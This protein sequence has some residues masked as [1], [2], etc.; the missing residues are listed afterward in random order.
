MS[1]RHR[2]RLFV[3]GAATIL[4]AFAEVLTLGAVV[5]LLVVISNPSRLLQNEWASWVFDVFGVTSAPQMVLFTTIVFAGLALTAGAFRIWLLWLSTRFVHQL[6][7]DVASRVNSNILHQ[8]YSYHVERHTG[9]MVAATMKAAAITGGVVM[10]LLQGF[11][12]LF[13]GFW[14]VVTVFLISPT[15][16]LIAGGMLGGAYLIIILL[17]RKKLRANG[18]IMATSQPESV[19]SV[20]EGLGGIRDVILDQSQA[21]FA[22]K[23][24]LA[25][26]KLQGARA[27]NTFLSRVPRFGV[28]AIGTAAIALVVM[29][30]NQGGDV[31]LVDVLPVI[32]ALALGAQ[33]LLP[34]I[35]QLFASYANILGGAQVLQET[36]DLLCLPLADDNATHQPKLP[37]TNS[38]EFSDI[39]LC[40]STQE[41]P[42]VQKLCFEI[43]KGERIGLI[44]KTGSGKSTTVD[45]LMG[46]ITPSAGSILVD[47]VPLTS[48]NQFAWRKNIAHVPQDIFLADASLLENIVFGLPVHEVDPARVREAAAL[49]KIDTF[50]ET[51]PKKYETKVGER[52]VRLSGGQRQRIGL[53]RALYKQAPVLI[54]DEATSALDSSTEKEVIRSIVDMNPNLTIVMIAHRVTTLESCDKIIELQAGKV[55]QIK[56]YK[57]IVSGG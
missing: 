30:L 46:L 4:G 10:P 37:F 11:S 40:Y 24:D 21:V 9:E 49:A 14:I 20:Q 17:T 8:N 55:A 29:L 2:Q 42:V 57:D 35:Q 23:F 33:R 41:P 43:Q 15:A 22:K 51:L 26:D 7:R 44:G 52:G 25:V 54:L 13:I 28:E 48:E 16:M 32:G 31:E 45:L 3:V 39:E 50:I 19:K 5:P 18:K 38:I 34:L 1:R 53:A 47:N 6:S 27:I 56:S 12:A 36:V